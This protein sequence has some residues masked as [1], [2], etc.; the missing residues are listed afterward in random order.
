[1]PIS[2]SSS[3]SHGTMH[4]SGRAI[5]G[6]FLLAVVIRWAY[7]LVIYAT[8]GTPGLLLADSH[9][10]LKDAQQLARAALSGDVRG[11]DWLGPDLSIMP[12]FPWL[13]ALT[14]M[15]AGTL[16]PLIW[17]MVQGLI[18]AGT[19]LLVYA[20]AASFAPRFALAAGIAA[21]LNPTQV[22]LSGLLYPDILFLF[23]ATAAL[24]GCVRW[25]RSP[26]WYWAVL[27]GLSLGAAGFTRVLVAPWTPCVILFLLGAVAIRKQLS[28]RHIGQVAVIGGIV[29][30]S[31]S[32]VLARN[33]T[34]YGSWALTPQGGAHLALWIVPLAK[35][36]NDGTPWA[37]GASQMEVEV[38]KR[39]PVGSDNR[40]E[41]ARRYGEVGREALA[42]LGVA[43]IAKAWIAG[44]VINLASPAVTL[45]PAV[46][47]LPRTGFYATPAT[48]TAEK[49]VNFLFRSDNALYA[50][51]ILVG[52]TGVIAFRL[53]QLVGLLGLVREPGAFIPLLLLLMWVGY[54]LVVNGPVASPKY[55]LPIEPVLAVLTGVGFCVLRDWRPRRRRADVNSV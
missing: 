45:S 44:A 36:A 27:I 28:G 52:M 5:L 21:S 50:W 16:A 48:T 38:R 2:H 18:D 14:V 19:S 53:L 20:I 24:L 23:F 6:V 7:G 43:R 32:P 8:M 33:V 15:A 17:I 41:L 37:T 1:M 22:V 10:Y 39:Y 3:I 35:E 26:S 25:L 42:Q 30:L 49:A 13:L 55:R 4:P 54:V 11:W 34:Q 9:A 31:L 40:F 47:Q 29:L 12:L 46:S 51:I